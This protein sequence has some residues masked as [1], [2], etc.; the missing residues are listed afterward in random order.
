LDQFENQPKDGST[1]YLRDMEREIAAAVAEGTVVVFASGNGP[2]PGSWPSS[3]PG[4]VS[5][6]GALVDEKLDLVAS[7]YATSF[8]SLVYPGRTCPDVCGIV[9]PAPNGLLLALPTQPN[10]QFDA[11][12]SAVDG[13]RP[14]DGWLIASGTSSA[15]PQVAGLVALLLQMEPALTPAGI[16]MRL[17]DVAVGVHHGES[18]SGHPATADRPNAATGYGFATFRRPHREKGYSGLF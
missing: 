5:V 6:G 3:A 11:E 17:K 18:A 13:T 2:A 9:G 15:T 10:N 4:V 12:F 7:S 14:G 1:I 8:V 16:A